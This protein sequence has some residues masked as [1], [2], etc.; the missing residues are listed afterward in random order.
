[1]MH[2]NYINQMQQNNIN[3]LFMPYNDNINSININKEK[4]QKNYNLDD[5]TIDINTE[6]LNKLDKENL[7][8]III[9]IRD[10]CKLKI[11][12]KFCHL[13]HQIFR[14]RKDKSKYNGR[15]FT[16]KKKGLKL[17]SQKFHQ[18]DEMD[19][20]NNNSDSNDDDDENN[21]IINEQNIINNSNSLINNKNNICD[22]FYCK[23]HN[24]VY[25]NI[26]SEAHCKNHIK[27][28][29][30]GYEFRK[31]KTLKTHMKYQH[32]EYIQNEENDKIKC[33]ECNLLLNSSELM[34]I[35]YNE[36]HDKNY[37]QNSINNEKEPFQNNVKEII[38]KSKK[39]N[40]DDLKKQ[41]EKEE[42]EKKKKDELRKLGEKER[43]KKEEEEELERHEE[44]KKYEE[45]KKQE[46]LRR[47]EEEKNR[48][49]EIKIQLEEKQKLEQIRKQQEEKR[50]DNLILPKHKELDNFTREEYYYI[51]YHDGKTFEDE[52]K[53][54]QH[55][56]KFHSDDFP[57]YCDICEKGFNS[58]N[59]I[60][61]HNRA[62][63]H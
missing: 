44:L 15:L 11:E 3:N 45:L 56:N 53:Y 43:L 21:N 62:K 61:Q 30:C 59:A 18:F 46:I 25:I 37:S 42:L 57:F 54:M 6:T 47:K 36:I 52:S 5:L 49:E 9:F 39:E 34:N 35:H 26:D 14:I 55:F 33:P 58:Y 24:K 60:D 10:I 23:V 7:I 1:M 4:T 32:Q 8:D 17:L 20:I 28:E 48:I 40:I 27:C 63:K 31:Y 22:T 12:L 51:C 41:K 2:L 38:N 19:N 13:K 29:K 50:P 16:I